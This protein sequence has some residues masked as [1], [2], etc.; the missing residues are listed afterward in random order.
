MY[1]K[2]SVKC[3]KIEM[4]IFFFYNRLYMNGAY[5]ERKKNQMKTFEAIGA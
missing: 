1:E 5:I 2:Q 3:S 4:I